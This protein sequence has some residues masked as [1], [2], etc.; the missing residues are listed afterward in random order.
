MEF[1]RKRSLA[2]K[3][4]MGAIWHAAM[5]LYAIRVGFI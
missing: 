5:T 3:E 4:Q 1:Y 2:I